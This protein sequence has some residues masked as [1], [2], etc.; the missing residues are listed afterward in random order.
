MGEP[1]VVACLA[2]T[3]LCFEVDPVSGDVRVDWRRCDLSL[4]DQAALELALRAGEAWGLPV[5]AVAAGPPEIERVLRDVL[6]LGVSALRVASPA[7]GWTDAWALAAAL[8]TAI[9][10]HA[11]PMLVLCGDRSPLRGTG[12]VPALLAAEL[13]AAAALGLVAVA[14]ETDP[15]SVRAERRLDGGWRERLRVRAPAVCSV[16]AAGVRLRRASLASTVHAADQPVPVAPAVGPPPVGAEVLR[17]GPPQPYRP[18]TK[19][20]PAPGGDTQD[21]LLALTGALKSHDPPRL[22]GPVSAEQGA[23]ELIEYL[24]GHGYWSGSER[25]G[26]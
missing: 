9:G 14:F 6:A 25:A 7:D 21:R 11:D 26:G 3:D 24:S 23:E 22:V 10:A 5:L 17:V 16:E 13:G 4:A 2:P 8:A 20:V 19:L 1:S 15:P 18:R 12:E